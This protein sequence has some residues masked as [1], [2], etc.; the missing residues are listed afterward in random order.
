MLDEP[1]AGL[2][3]AETADLARFLDRIAAEGT[4][5]L[6][7]EH[8]MSF[9]HALC[10]RVAVLNFGR[11]IYEGSMAGAARDAQVREAYLGSRHGEGADAA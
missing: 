1:A 4:T 9:V 5:L 3:P 7:V 2:N 8:D 11:K 10:D 6:V